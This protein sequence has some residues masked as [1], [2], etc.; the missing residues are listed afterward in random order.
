MKSNEE[1]FVVGSLIAASFESSRAISKIV[2]DKLS[3]ISAIGDE[4]LKNIYILRVLLSSVYL[5]KDGRR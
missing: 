5:R 4:H 2:L 1:L 3:A